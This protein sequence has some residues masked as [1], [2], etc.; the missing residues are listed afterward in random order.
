[1]CEF[2]EMSD[3]VA[4]GKFKVLLKKIKSCVSFGLYKNI[5]K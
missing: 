3:N 4:G 1:M 2:K 5:R